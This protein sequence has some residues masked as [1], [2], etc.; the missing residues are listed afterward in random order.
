MHEQQ[1]VI[2][3]LNKKVTE[4]EKR[5]NQQT[6]QL[7]QIAATVTAAGVA[8]EESERKTLKA[9]HAEL[10]RVE[11]RVTKKTTDVAAELRNESTRINR[12][13]LELVQK[14]KDRRDRELAAA[15]AAVASANAARK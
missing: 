10:G 14:E 3:S 5:F 9:L 2:I 15:N 13:V 8:L 6:T 12:V 4:F 1:S 7:T 11:Q